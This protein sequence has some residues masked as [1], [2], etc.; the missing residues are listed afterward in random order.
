MPCQQL[1]LHCRNIHIY[2]MNRE[3]ESKSVVN[4]VTVKAS[5]RHAEPPTQA[6]VSASSTHYRGPLIV[7]KN[8]PRPRSVLVLVRRSQR[9]STF[10]LLIPGCRTVHTCC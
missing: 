3:I 2:I 1:L 6:K 9:L 5:D 10:V 7:T 4:I 8:I